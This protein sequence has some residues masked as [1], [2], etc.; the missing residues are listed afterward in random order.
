[1]SKVI[2]NDKQIKLLA[3]NPN[4][5]K[6]SDK[7]ITYSEEFKNKF[8]EENSKG[9]LPR[10]IFED[11][12]FDIEIIGLKRIEQAA[13]RWRKKYLDMG[14]LGLKDSRTSNSGRPLLR[15]L[16]AQEEIERL[17]AKISLLEIE[18]EFLKKLDEIERK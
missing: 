9:I 16:T 12:G 2:F 4:V 6:V 5:L 1:M 15:E 10:K 7:A 11:N 18:N 17:K 3:K 8:I 13:A 14:V